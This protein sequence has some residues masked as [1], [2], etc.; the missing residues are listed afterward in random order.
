MDLTKTVPEE[1]VE[2]QIAPLIDVVFLLLIYFMVTTALIKKE[3]DISFM[4]PASVD[5]V[6]PIDL[7]IEVTIEIAPD[8]DVMVE[9]VLFPASDSEL[10]TLATRLTEFR[11]AAESAGSELVVNILPENEVMHGRIIDVMNACA[12]ANVKNTSFTMEM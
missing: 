2:L 1:K 3:A 10:L 9:G 4:L 12:I 5:Q 11:Q 6:E 7:P 8:G